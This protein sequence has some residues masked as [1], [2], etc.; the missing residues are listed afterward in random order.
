MTIARAGLDAHLDVDGSERPH[1]RLAQAVGAYECGDHDHGEGQHYGL[2]Q[3]GHDRRHRVGQFHLPEQ[4]PPVG[5][6]SL[7]GF[8]KLLGYRVHAKVGQP[9]W[10]RDGEDHGRDESRHYAEPEQ[11]Q[12]GDEVDEG[13]DGL[14]QVEDRPDHRIKPRPMRRGDTDRNPD[15]HADQGG[16]EHQGQGFQGLLPVPLVDDQQQECRDAQ[17]QPQ[18]TVQPPGQHRDRGDQGQ[19]RARLHQRRQAFYDEF[20]QG[21]QQV[22]EGREVVYEEVEKTGDP[23]AKRNLVIGDLRGQPIHG[24]THC[25]SSGDARTT[26]EPVERAPPGYVFV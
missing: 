3:A 23:G 11:D 25:P 18:G 16:E 7:A 19:R 4:L 21:R 17:H 12:S 13:G 22:E 10:C 20:K 6:E 9:D 8:Q 2:R 26:S 1:H 5:T 14:H 15:E 24:I